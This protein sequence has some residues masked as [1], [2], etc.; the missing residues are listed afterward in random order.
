MHWAMPNTT[1]E[2][3]HLC[4][5][6]V[7]QLPRGPVLLIV[8]NEITYLESENWEEISFVIAQL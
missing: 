5:D 8:F 2:L 7:E 1:L 6:L 3:C 4:S